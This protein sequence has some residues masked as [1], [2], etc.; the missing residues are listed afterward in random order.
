MKI[1]LIGAGNVATGLAKF[2]ATNGHELLFTYSRDEEKLKRTAASVSA[3]AKTG[4]P[5]QAVDFAD[6]LVLATPWTATPAACEALKGADGKIVMSCVNA[7]KPDYSGLDVGTT[8]S[9][10]EQIA[11]WL[12]QAKV[13][14][15]LPPFAEL[16]Q[17]GSTLLQGSA[18]TVFVA[19]EDAQAKQKVAG[20]LAESGADVIDAGPLSSARFIEPAMFLLVQLAYKQGSADALA[21][22]CCGKQLRHCLDLTRSVC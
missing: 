14:E 1:G 20:L 21:C 7:L 22:D 19:G 18:P 15:A 5:Q 17:S 11:A 9:A 2:W 3:T 6:V 10:G 4:S 13:V 12:P 8:T 16:L